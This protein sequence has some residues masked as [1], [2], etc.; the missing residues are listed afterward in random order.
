MALPRQRT[1]DDLGAPL[2]E[3]SFCVLDL[4]TTGGSPATCEITEIGAVKY[5]GGE[6]TGTFDTLVNPGAPIPPTITVL[7]GI[8]QAM[9]IEA[10]RIGEVI[11][12]LLEFIGTSVIVGHNIRFDMSF[13][14]AAAER[15]GYGK[16][17]NLTVD[18]L[19][20]ARRLVNGETRRMNLGS[21]AAHFRS[22]ITPNHR[23]LADA[24]ATAHV[25]WSLLERA[26]TIGVS[27]LEDLL[28]L[29]TAKGSPHYSKIS[30]TEALPRRPG[31]YMFR[32]RDSNVI[33]VGKAKN[34]RTR[35]RSYFYGDNRRSVA[36]MLRDLAAIDFIVCNTEIEAEVTELRM[37]HAN[38]P[39]YN[40]RSRPPR[41][42]QYVKLT[43]EE[44]PRLSIVRNRRD[45]GCLYLGPFRSRRTA[46]AVVSALWDAVPIR[47]CITRA[48][49]RSPACNFAQLGVALCPCDGT[50]SAAEYQ[51]VVTQLRDGIESEPGVLLEPLVARIRD[52]ASTARF[53][54]AAELRDRHRALSR[55]LED[56]RNWL[57]IRGAGLLW[58]ED[59]AG[60]SI[61]IEDG[62]LVTSWANPDQ[63]PLGATCVASAEPFD[64]PRS[65]VDAEEA[66]LLWRWLDRPDVHIV[67]TSRPLATP[68]QPVP[69][70]TTLAG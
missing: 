13:L 2:H 37:I 70:L 68:R 60:D 50:V 55:A 28:R 6:L 30:L 32:D 58:A 21:L 10:P 34:L 36:Q 27:H 7:T 53:E 56:R 59:G 47:R 52:Y 66:R 14:N 43:A 41:S 63:P 57:V 33:Y 1:F 62:R 9:V 19:G 65:V 38:A 48:G 42:P 64:V 15:L 3:V 22:P 25:F 16:L 46:N 11:P 44:F 23:A 35:V 26:G 29:P 4:E 5:V 40:R 67:E 61:L 20:L 31:V 51:Q 49:K 69:V 8:T 18:T 45:D 24:S 39:R 12:S 54:E 17:T